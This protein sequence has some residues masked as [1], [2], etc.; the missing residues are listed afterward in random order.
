[1][2][3]SKMVKKSKAK[4]VFISYDSRQ[5]ELFPRSLDSLLDKNHPARVISDVVDGLDLT[6]IFATYVGGGRSSYH[7]KM[8]LKVIFYAYLNNIYSCRD[9][10]KALKENVAFMWLSGKQYPDFRT[11]NLF[12]TERIGE[13]IENIFKEVVQMLMLQNFISLSVQYVDGTKI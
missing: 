9:I 1:M 4:P 11:I 3:G 13:S 6:K 7:P 10:A 8:M 12:R 2:L 5:V